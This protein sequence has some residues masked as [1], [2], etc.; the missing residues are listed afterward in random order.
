M[1]FYGLFLPSGADVPEVSGVQ[2]VTFCPTVAA[3]KAVRRIV[4][5]H[6]WNS[7]VRLPDAGGAF[8]GCS[9]ISRR[10]RQNTHRPKRKKQRTHNEREDH[11][12]GKVREHS[13]PVAF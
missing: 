5:L 4:G 13:L 2:N 8:P 10:M 7:V 9:E 3:R 12:P 6:S 1:L 11:R